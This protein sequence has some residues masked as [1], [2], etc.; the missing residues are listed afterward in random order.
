MKKNKK[1]LSLIIALLLSL[2]MIIIALYILNYMFFFMKSTK[3]IENSVRAYYFADSGIEDALYFMSTA[4]L[5]DTKTKNIFDK[6]W[7]YAIEM[8]ASWMIL[9]PIW[10]WNSEFDKD[11]NIIRTWKPIQIEVWNDIIS[12]LSQFKLFFRVPDF[13]KDW[14]SDDW[15]LS[16]ATL[17]IINWQLI[18]ENNILNAS[19]SQITADQINWDLKTWKAIFVSS[20]KNWRTLFDSEETFYTF[21]NNNCWSWKSCILKMSVIN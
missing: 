7:D 8:I 19:G 9:P 2:I 5:W 14:S 12:P 13:N 10:E 20:N 16:W 3:W 4:N 18:W 21:Y 17:K 6:K 1:A 11:Y 15:T